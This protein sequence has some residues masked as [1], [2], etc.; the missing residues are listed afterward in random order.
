MH[1]VTRTTTKIPKIINNKSAKKT[2]VNNKISDYFL[3]NTSSSN[4]SSTDKS[5][6]NNMLN[7]IKKYKEL[8]NK[9]NLE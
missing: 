9:Y 2:F 3:N 7:D 5:S 4:K 8:S 6:S 1:F